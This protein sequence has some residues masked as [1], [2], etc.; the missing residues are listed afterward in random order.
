MSDIN[1]VF[2]QYNKQTDIDKVPVS[3]NRYGAPHTLP[4]FRRRA[5]ML[6]QTCF[7]GCRRRPFPIQLHQYAKSTHSD[8]FLNFKNHW[9]NIYILWYLEWPVQ[10]YLFYDW[11]NSLGLAG[12]KN[13]GEE[14]GD[15]VNHFIWMTLVSAN[16]FKLSLSTVCTV[17]YKLLFPVRSATGKHIP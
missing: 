10:Q 15:S 8:F 2:R 16:Y 12:A 1:L 7:A 17:N 5:S 3:W 6:K 14:E 11:R 9:C 13:R 4:I